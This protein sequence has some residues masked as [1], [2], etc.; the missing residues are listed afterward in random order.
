MRA[1]IRSYSA[2]GMAISHHESSGFAASR[3]TCALVALLALFLQGS[4]GGHVLLVE[5]TR[6]AEHGELVHGEAS[7][8]HLTPDQRSTEGRRFERSV[9]ASSDDAHG[10]CAP[11]ADRRDALPSVDAPRPFVGLALADEASLAQDAPVVQQS[12][13]FRIAP[14]NSPPA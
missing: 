14:K 11:F 3:R 4:T 7:H 8:R 13:R 5:H 12:N 1:P 6:C 10:H 9:P 2:L